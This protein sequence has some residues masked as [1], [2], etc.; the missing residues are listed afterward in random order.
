[1]DFGGTTGKRWLGSIEVMASGANLLESNI[2]F[3]SFSSD[4]EPPRELQSSSMD[5][6]SEATMADSL[7]QEQK[8]GL[9][10]MVCL[11]RGHHL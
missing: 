5:V 1:M 9:K 4:F 10:L 3:I 7:P 6:V 2:T 11:K 8:R